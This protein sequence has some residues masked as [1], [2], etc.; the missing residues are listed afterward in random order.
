MQ[1]SVGGWS[2]RSVLAA[3]TWPIKRNFASPVLQR[4]RACSDDASLWL[5]RRC[6]APAPPCRSQAPP[7]CSEAV[8]MS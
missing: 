3:A 4:R 6:A 5:V 1:C 2:R 8:P 7:R